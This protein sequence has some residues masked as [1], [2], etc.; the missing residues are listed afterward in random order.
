VNAPRCAALALLLVVVATT[1]R[2]SRA[3][4]PRRV[5]SFV[6]GPSPGLASS[7]WLDA[8]DTSVACTT[9]PRAPTVTL[10]LRVP[11]G[12]G[13]APASDADGNLIIAHGEARISKLDA[14]GRTLWSQRLE[15]EA[16]TAPLPL[17]DGTILVVTHGADALLFSATGHPTFAR[18]LP[19][20]GSKHRTLAIPT[21][22]GGALVASG[23]DVLELDRTGQVTRQLQAPAAVA[24]LAQ[25][26]SKLIAITENGIVAEARASGGFELVGS[27]G[28]AV[29]EG[30]AVRDGKLF[31]VVDNHK[32]VSFELAEGRASVL[33]S[34][35]NVTLSGPPLSF[36]NGASAL[37]ADGG[38]LAFHAPSGA[39]ILRVSIAETGRAFDPATRA[40]KPALAIG[41]LAFGLAATRSGADAI[42]VSA[43]GKAQRLDDSACLDPFRPTPTPKAVV[44]ACRSGQL[45]WVTD[46]AP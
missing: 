6:L 22:N 33:A 24:G 23:T 16:A 39:E 13:Q 31:A 11:G 30:G 10:R 7:E 4:D 27:L 37:I 40:L 1:A 21:Q 19:L 25:A 12:I 15:S 32:L 3:D 44:L 42:F 20:E 9:F 26:G 41:D 28:G 34:D 2:S 17:A 18:P 14:H 29:P 5:H 38:F 8:A 45:F 35:S 46:K 36:A 43:D